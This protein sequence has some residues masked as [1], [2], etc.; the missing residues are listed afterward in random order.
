[1]NEARATGSPTLSTMP[2]L[3]TPA[4]LPS[5]ATRALR[6]LGVVG[7]WL[8]G[9]APV[10]IGTPRCNVAA[11]LHRPCPGCGM[12]RAVHL[13]RD[14]EVLASLRLHPLTVPI[15]AITIF[16]AGV[17]VWLTWSQG[18]PLRIWESR[19]GRGATWAMVAVHVAVLV[20]WGLRAFG[21]FGG[22]VS[23]D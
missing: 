13:L 18:T 21:L 1:M 19:L 2:P 15:I 8:L 3:P 4:P 11:V 20:F 16:F 10:L 17:T 12:T 9:V 7:A 23:V 5:A 14:G 22:P 6:A